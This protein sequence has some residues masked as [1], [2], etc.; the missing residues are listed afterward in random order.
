[1]VMKSRRKPPASAT[2]VKLAELGF[3]APQVIAHR[4]TRMALAGPTISARDRREFTGMVMEKQAA[5][6]Q[7]WMGMFAE[8][9]RFQQQFA[10]SLLTGAT[11]RRHA[12][13]AKSAA[14]RI[15]SAGLAP[16]HRKAVANAKRLAGTKIR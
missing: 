13:R 9:V 6:A 15:T 7:A 10:L 4:L 3:A 11:P 14:S 16:I 1:M 8:A 12:A 5:V 2:A